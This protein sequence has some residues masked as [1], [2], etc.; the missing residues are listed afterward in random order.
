MAEQT[1]I[2]ILDPV[3]YSKNLVCGGHNPKVLWTV[4][5]CAEAMTKWAEGHDELC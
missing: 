1:Y 3:N 5:G 2:K 4:M